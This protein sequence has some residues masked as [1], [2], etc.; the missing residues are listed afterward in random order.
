[1]SKE[2]LFGTEHL[3]RGIGRLSDEVLVAGEGT[4][5]TTDQGKKLLDMAA[6]IGVV[7]LGHCHPAVTKATQEQCARLTHAQVN[8]ALSGPQIDLMRELLTIMPDKSLDSFF[9]WN[10]GTEAIEAAV[11]VARGAT[12]RSHIIVMQGSYH[13]RTAGSAAMTRS[14]TIY[15]EHHGPLMPDVYT[16][17]FPYY[18]QLCVPFGTPE[19]ELVR[20]SLDRLRLVLLQ[21]TAPS[22]TAAIVIETALGEGGYVPAPAAFL[23]GVREICDE[24]GILYVADEIQCGYGRTG[25]MF[26]VEHAGVRPDIMAFAKGLANGF[27]LSGIVASKAIMDKMAPGSLGGTYAGNAVSCAAAQAV[28]RVFRDEKVLENVAARGKQLVDA[29][30]ALQKTPAGKLIEDI[31]GLGLMIG[32]QF[33]TPSGKQIKGDISQAC[34]KRNMFLLSTSSFDVIRWIPPLTVSESELAQGIAIFREALDE[35]A[36]DNGFL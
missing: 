13:G 23:K 12:R 17:P 27:P 28:V 30:T 3:T 1:M 21:E 20:L 33:R 34:L 32:V 10:S 4:W 22:D 24:H 6:G 16:V 15:G 26:A 11:Q 7:S 9:L 2:A 35:V 25:R 18:S 5:V 14:K 36:R 29:M 19:E 31:R 8:I